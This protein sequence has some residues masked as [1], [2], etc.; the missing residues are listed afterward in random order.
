MEVASDD[1]VVCDTEASAVNRGS[2]SPWP[3]ASQ[4]PSAE[5]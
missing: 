5:H 3:L 1:E 2:E 4:A